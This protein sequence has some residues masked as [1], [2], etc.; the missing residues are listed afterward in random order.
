MCISASLTLA[1]HFFPVCAH[2]WL[3]LK[4]ILPLSW[5][6][7][8]CFTHNCGKWAIW[9][10]DCV[11]NRSCGCK[12]DII[13][14]QTADNGSTFLHP[15][16]E[17]AL[18]HAQCLGWAPAPCDPEQDKWFRKWMAGSQFDTDVCKQWQGLFVFCNFGN[19][20]SPSFCKLLAFTFWNRLIILL[21]L[22]DHY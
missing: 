21:T 2:W 10:T 13:F 4:Q 14:M 12:L 22:R 6:F 19:D 17:C 1:F 7:K 18:L 3:R 16:T 11:M 8:C 20:G 5:P 9:L 15:L